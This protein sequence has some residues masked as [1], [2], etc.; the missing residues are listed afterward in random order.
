MALAKILTRNSCQ[1]KPL[2][3]LQESANDNVTSRIRAKF[4]LGVLYRVE[5]ATFNGYFG[6]KDLKAHGRSHASTRGRHQH[7]NTGLHIVALFEA[8]K[9][10]LPPH[11][12]RRRG[13]G[14]R[15]PSVGH[16]A[17]GDSFRLY[18][19]RRLWF[20]AKPSLGR[21]VRYFIRQP[22]SSGRNI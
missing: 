14:N 8:A 15:C 11:L 2:D 13:E 1:L 6:L 4:T 18:P 10:A 21:V 5:I 17:D 16:G 22:V 20:M 7:D 19:V 12:Y 9:G 3:H